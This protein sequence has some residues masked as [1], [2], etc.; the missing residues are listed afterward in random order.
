MKQLMLALAVLAFAVAVAAPASA[1]HSFAAEFD[2]NK[3]V[4]LNGFVTK[5][6]WSNPH[7]WFYINVKKEDGSV[8]NWG[9]EM[10]PPH[11]LQTTGWTRTTMKLGDE[12]IVNGFMAKNGTKRANARAVT[13][14]VTGARLGAGSSQQPLNQQ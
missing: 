5:I 10:G 11:L 14:A 8:E 6:E 2:G 1:H 7:V 12:V 4:T 3:P 13:M 9:F